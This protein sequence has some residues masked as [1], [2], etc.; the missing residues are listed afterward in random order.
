MSS[1]DCAIERLKHHHAILA[2][3]RRHMPA[4]MKRAATHRRDVKPRDKARHVPHV[5]N[6]GD[7][8][9]RGCIGLDRTMRARVG[10]SATETCRLQIG[11]VGARVWPA[12]CP[13]PRAPERS[14][15]RL[16]R[17]PTYL[18]TPWLFAHR[19]QRHGFL[20]LRQ[21]AENVAGERD[22]QRC[23]GN[24][25]P[26]SIM[27]GDALKTPRRNSSCAWEP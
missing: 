9:A 25:I 11:S 21:A 12:C 3:H 10:I 4:D 24:V 8:R 17:C 14:P 5:G 7:E 13:P 23:A 26:R 20:R 22:A 1:L 18:A 16:P 6:R 27:S 15:F 19:R 2:D